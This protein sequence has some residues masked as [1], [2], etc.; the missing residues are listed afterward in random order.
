MGQKANVVCSHLSIN[1]TWNAFWFGDLKIYGFLF[2]EDFMIF[3]FLRSNSKIKYDILKKKYSFGVEIVKTSLYRTKKSLILSLG[4]VCFNKKRVKDFVFCLLKQLQKL[5]LGVK[6]FISYKLQTKTAFFLAVKIGLLLEKRVRFQSSVIKNL[7]KQS[8]FSGIK[9]VCK[10]RLNFKDRAK[11]AH[12]VF[13]FLPQQTFDANLDYS[14]VVANTLKGLQS[15]KV[16]VS[17]F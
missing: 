10:G 4:L 17:Q 16:W 12:I 1:K 2:Q 5:F 13:G 8:K 14:C 11:K 7:I 15:I 3:S 6:I 9:I